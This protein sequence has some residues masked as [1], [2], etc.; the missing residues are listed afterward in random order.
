VVPLPAG[1]AVTSTHD[2]IAL[3]VRGRPVPQGSGRSFVSGSRAIHVTTS[4]PLLAWRGAIATE[5]RTGMAGRPLLEGP[6]A[7]EVEFRPAARPARHW[8]P[9]NARRLLRVLR[10]DAPVHHAS[11]PDID[12]L[13]RAVMDALSSVVWVDDR[14]VARLVASKPRQEQVLLL[15]GD[16][17]GL[18]EIAARLGIS[19]WTVRTYRDE[20]RRRL[21]ARTTAQAAVLVREQRLASR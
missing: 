13:C 10:L 6:V 9:A 8:L 20:G 7:L 4:A 11:A 14:Q 17:M 21:G 5:A 16:G 3:E 18:G 1:V 15:L 19:E 12:K 2:V